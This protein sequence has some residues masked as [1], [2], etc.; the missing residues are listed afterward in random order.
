MELKA[1]ESLC[2]LSTRGREDQRC[3]DRLRTTP[4]STR[5]EF[6]ASKAWTPPWATSTECCTCHKD[7]LDYKVL[8]RACFS[9]F[10]ICL[11][12]LKMF[13]ERLLKTFE[14]FSCFSHLFAFGF[15][16]WL[17]PTLL[18]L[19]LNSLPRPQHIA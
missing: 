9:M 3:K 16:P 8:Q 13:S 2:H 6:Q 14:H 5:G 19:S 7:D 1:N 11:R 4:I 17:E 12:Y 15:S 10:F 18:C